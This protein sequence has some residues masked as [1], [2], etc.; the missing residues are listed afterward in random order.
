M[1][2][3]RYFVFVGSVLVAL[4]FAI[5]RYL[6]M[7]PE[8]GHASDPD[9]TIIRIR[10]AR[11]LPEKIVFDTRPQTAA[12]SFADVDPIPEPVEHTSGDV[13]PA[14]AA[15]PTPAATKKE[16]PVRKRAENRLRKKPAAK[17]ST[18]TPDRRLASERHDFFAG[19]WW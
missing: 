2:I 8:T 9:K 7:P 16:A 10:S 17:P 5:D 18:I 13:L 14:M 1:P 3:I 4:L 11:S 12:P 19:S 6:P 15:A